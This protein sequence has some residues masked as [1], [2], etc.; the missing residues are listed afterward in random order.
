[1][2][3]SFHRRHIDFVVSQG[4]GPHPRYESSE[5]NIEFQRHNV[6]NEQYNRTKRRQRVMHIDPERCSEPSLELFLNLFRRGHLFLRAG[7][8]SF[9][10]TSMFTANLSS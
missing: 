7:T 1:M 3:R 4:R 8:T 9:V 2:G 5:T 6:Y 10:N